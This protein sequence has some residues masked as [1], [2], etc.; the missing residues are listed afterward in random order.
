MSEKRMTRMNERQIQGD[1]IEL[2]WCS[3]PFASISQFS[4]R[5]S[6]TRVCEGN[7]PALVVVDESSYSID[8]QCI[9]EMLDSKR[10]SLVPVEIDCFQRLYAERK[11]IQWS[12]RKNLLF[13]LDW[14]SKHLRCIRVLDEQLLP[15][16]DRV[17][18]V[19]GQSQTSREILWNQRDHLLLD[20]SLE[21]H[22]DKKFSYSISGS[23]EDPISSASVKV[24]IGQAGESDNDH[25]R[26][27]LFIFNDSARYCISLGLIP[28]LCIISVWRHWETW[29]T[30][31][32]NS[33]KTD[34]GVTR[35]IFNVSAN[36]LTVYSLG[37]T[38]STFNVVIVEEKSIF[39]FDDFPSEI[40]PY[41]IVAQRQDNFCRIDSF[42]D[43]RSDWFHSSSMNDTEWRSQTVFTD[44]FSNRSLHH[45]RWRDS[46]DKVET[47]QWFHSTLNRRHEL[48]T[49]CHRDTNNRRSDRRVRHSFGNVSLSVK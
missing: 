25:P 49:G 45:R 31:M 23:I 30:P 9:G 47:C 29:R 32:T 20:S 33:M 38:R 6:S 42:S 11:L 39:Y 35:L 43:H 48:R 21:H 46:P 16:S 19:S 2:D 37:T 1:G 10:S 40:P 15:I 36:C 13:S 28:V 12:T 14:S 22:S 17:S 3:V 34:F 4:S 41:Q 24:G 26:L 27:T 44:L 5:S 18:S 7:E 8:L